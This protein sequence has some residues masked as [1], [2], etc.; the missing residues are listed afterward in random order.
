MMCD[1]DEDFIAQVWGLLEVTGSELRDRQANERPQR[2]SASSRV[3]SWPCPRTPLITRSILF[4][5][6]SSSSSALHSSEGLIFCMIRPPPVLRLAPS[7]RTVCDTLSI[8][9][10]TFLAESHCNEREKG[11]RYET[12]S[13]QQSRTIK[14][15][16]FQFWNVFTCLG[17]TLWW[18]FY[19]HTKI[20]LGS[21][22]FR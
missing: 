14:W 15:H 13:L 16:Y 10:S 6:T 4:S 3:R 22:P 12:K 9:A 5:C 7:P 19:L 17:T 20:S 11:S 2:W 1:V 18:H 21:F 8:S